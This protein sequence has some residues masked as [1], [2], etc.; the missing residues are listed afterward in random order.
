[1]AY[2]NGHEIARRN[3]PE[4]EPAFNSQ[5][6]ASHAA[7][8]GETFVVPATFLRDGQNILAIHGLNRD[9]TDDDFLVL[10]E[11]I[12]RSVALGDAGYLLEP[13][14]GGFNGDTVA[15]FVADTSFDVDRGFFHAPF[16]V[17]ITTSTVGATLVYTTDGSV[18]S[19][20]NGTRVEPIDLAT[21]PVATVPISTT[22]TLRAAAFREGFA[23][24]N[25]DTHSYLFLADVIRQPARPPEMPTSWAGASADYQMDPDV[26]DDPAYRDEI[27]T[28]L[29]SIPTLSIVTDHANLW[30]ST[31]GI[32]IHSTQRGANW[33]RP[34]SI[35][36][37]EAGRHERIP[38]R[39]GY[40][41][42]GNRL[43]STQCIAKALVPAQIQTAVRA[44]ETEISSVPRCAGRRV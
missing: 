44:H 2:L 17:N 32:Y 27:L 15:G 28:G 31:D 13:T 16:E 12:G 30:D 4:G 36:L 29:R 5:A 40:S 43:G 7:G 8:T 23:S 41:D 35:E 25:V 24:T 11:L 19:L 22:T 6:T 9:P 37:I 34:V 20:T 3:A 33:E 14:P 26:V 10:P 39:R 18:P 1:M 21:T 42:V 38:G